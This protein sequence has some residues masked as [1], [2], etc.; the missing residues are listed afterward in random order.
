MNE[1]T[2]YCNGG[3]ARAVMAAE[4]SPVCVRRGVSDWWMHDV[5]R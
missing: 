2:A 5:L 4:S 1:P 3:W